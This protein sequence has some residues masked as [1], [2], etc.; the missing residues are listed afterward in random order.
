MD[1]NPVVQKLLD[2]QLLVS[3][4]SMYTVLD[5]YIKDATF[6]TWNVTNVYNTNLVRYITAVDTACSAMADTDLLANVTYIKDTATTLQP[7]IE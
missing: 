7:N 5:A 6:T 2:A 1:T 4:Q 3:A